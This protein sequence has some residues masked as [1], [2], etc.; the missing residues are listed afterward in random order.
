MPEAL[1]PSAVVAVDA[2]TLWWSPVCQELCD[3]REATAA[4]EVERRDVLGQAN[5][6]VQRQEQRVDHHPG[7]ACRPQQQTRHR[8]GRGHEVDTVV[9]RDGDGGEAVL[10]GPPRHLQAL[11][12][13]LRFGHRR[14]RRST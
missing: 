11:R 3:E 1:R 13:L 7:V 5:R 6:V 8:R 9:L 10:V 2:A 14:E 12:V 4:G